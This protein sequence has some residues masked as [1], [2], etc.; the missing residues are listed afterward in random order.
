[1]RWSGLGFN[2]YVGK[3]KRPM[4]SKFIT[5]FEALS[6][7]HM[8]ALIDAAFNSEEV[9]WINMCSI[10]RFEKKDRSSLKEYLRQ[11][12]RPALSL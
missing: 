10:Y 2:L 6:E 8:E 7:N 5:Q 12:F 1:M 9:I 11:R 4:E 3:E